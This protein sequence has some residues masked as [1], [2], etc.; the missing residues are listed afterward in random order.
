M[1]QK[2]QKVLARVPSTRDPQLSYA[3]ASKPPVASSTID[4]ISAAAGLRRALLTVATVSLWE[5]PGHHIR[6]MVHPTKA[7]AYR[8]RS[9]FFLDRAHRVAR[10]F[11]RDNDA[12]GLLEFGQFV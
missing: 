1:L 4:L 3:R 9:L 12:L 11:G 5:W 8:S 2:R 6:L 10:E 7:L